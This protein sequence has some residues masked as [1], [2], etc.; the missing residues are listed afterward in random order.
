MRDFL[1][2]AINNNR[3][4]LDHLRQVSRTQTSQLQTS[5]QMLQNQTKN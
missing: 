1:N 3:I 5:Y 2:T 4:N